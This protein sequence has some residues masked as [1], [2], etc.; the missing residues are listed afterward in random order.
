M[1]IL[2]GE[3]QQKAPTIDVSGKVHIIGAEGFYLTVEGT[4]ANAGNYAVLNTTEWR[5]QIDK[6]CEEK[7][8]TVTAKAVMPDQNIPQVYE[9]SAPAPR[10]GW[11]TEIVDV[12][13]AQGNSIWHYR[14]WL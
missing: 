11:I 10:K 6:E 5:W 13:D 4:G 1:P 14:R 3:G 8:Y 2:P 9:H 7:G 12:K